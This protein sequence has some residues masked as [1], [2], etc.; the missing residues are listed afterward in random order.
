MTNSLFGY[1]VFTLP[2]SLEARVSF[3]S[4]F[5]GTRLS[6]S[7]GFLLDLVIRWVH[8]AVLIQS[9]LG[10]HEHQC[11]MMIVWVV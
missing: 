9:L 6:D 2:D 10:H 5:P 1:Q 7:R 3:L 11:V 4:R 8:V